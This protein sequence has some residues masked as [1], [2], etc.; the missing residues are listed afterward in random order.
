M[1]HTFDLRQTL[2]KYLGAILNEFEALTNLA[3]GTII[4]EY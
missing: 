3:D 1:I 4:L 2:P